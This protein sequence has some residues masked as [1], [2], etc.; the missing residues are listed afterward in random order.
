[1][2]V[3]SKEFSVVSNGFGGVIIQDKATRRSVVVSRSSLPTDSYI[4]ECHESEFNRVCRE[5]MG[6]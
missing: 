5:A 6:G 1:M 4:A 2:N 3:S